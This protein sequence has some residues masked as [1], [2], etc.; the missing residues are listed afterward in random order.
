M[1]EP[2]PAPLK[3]LRI[4]ARLNV[5]GPAR[6]VI[7][8]DREL[9]LR[10][11]ST[12]LA[13]GSVDSGEASL[14]HLA[15]EGN[16]ST[17]RI[18]G[19]GRRISPRSDARA[20]MELVGLAFRRTPDVIHTHTAKAGALGR[21]AAFLFNVSR[22]RKR[23]C[24]VVH[25]F[26]G[27]VFTGYF[28]PTAEML[29]RL[30]ERTLAVITDRIVAISPAQREDLV[31]RFQ[32]ASRPQTV[33]IPLGL[34]LDAIVSRQSSVRTLR[35]AL[36]IGDKHFVVG[37]VGRFVPIKNLELLV[38]A[39]D[40]TRRGRFDAWLILVGDGPTRPAVEA[41]VRTSG[42]SDR[43][44]FC[45]WTEELASVYATMDVCALSSINEGTPVAIIEAMAAGKAVVA[46]NVG[47]V[48]DV[49]EDGRT[50]LLV[51]PGNVEALAGALIRLAEDPDARDS[52]GAL[53][54][55]DVA[56]R[57]SPGRLV[58]D[59]ERLYVSA[60]AEKRGAR[61]VSSATIPAQD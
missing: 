19:L 1:P 57:F 46:T 18:P 48:P 41:L 59:I 61:S 45:G 26:H 35:S 27:H 25:T 8:L 40:L 37:Y 30:A 56:R 58:D 15:A 2:S 3:V 6:H 28:R 52:L 13:H 16:V 31:G 49:I 32:I 55:K 7:L 20:L 17:A 34:D 43:V 54:R 24:L 11:H 10:G 60:L 50:G 9:Q 5:G 38:R 14:E 39:F 12:L 29:V 51:P 42:L 36:G 23:R 21:I 4:I 22:S 53:A 44:R 33:M 47:G